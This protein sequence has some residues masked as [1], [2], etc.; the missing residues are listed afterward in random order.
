MPGELHR[1]VSTLLR[2]TSLFWSDFVDIIDIYF[3][4]LVTN[5]RVTYQLTCTCAAIQSVGG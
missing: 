3:I 2:F 1:M 4:S 5:I